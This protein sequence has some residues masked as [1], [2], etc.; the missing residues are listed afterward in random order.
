MRLFGKLGA[1]L[2]KKIILAF[3]FVSHFFQISIEDIWKD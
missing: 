2:E 1:N 3:K